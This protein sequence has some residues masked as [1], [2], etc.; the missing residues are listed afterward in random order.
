MFPATFP[1]TSITLDECANPG[2]VI[3]T[4]IIAAFVA[5]T[6]PWSRTR[7]LENVLADATLLPDG[8]AVIRHPVTRRCRG[9]KCHLRVT[10][11][12][13]IVH[14]ACNPYQRQPTKDM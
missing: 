1:P 10:P 2:A 3:D 8:G 5:G 4:M 13:V 14:D 11:A 12:E 7:Q 9:R 6:Q